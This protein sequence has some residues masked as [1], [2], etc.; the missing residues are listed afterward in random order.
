VTARAVRIVVIAVCAGGVAGMIV[1]SILD[2]N[3]AAL[4]FGLV[5]AVAVLCLM[6][7]T[8][9]TTDRLPA[10]AEQTA[11]ALE[12]AIGLLVASGADEMAVRNVAR[13]AVHLGRQQQGRPAPPP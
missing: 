11:A 2:H 1:S 7:A 4:T 9:V 8:A 3:G 5:T 12:D 10:D 13:T 6:V